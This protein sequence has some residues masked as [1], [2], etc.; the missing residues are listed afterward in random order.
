VQPAQ[1]FLTPM[2]ATEKIALAHLS[3]RGFQNV[4][5]EPD[6]NVPPDF[7]VD[8]RIAV[9][10]RRLNEHTKD[11]TDPRGLEE[12]AIPRNAQFRRLLASFGAPTD[13]ISWFVS[14][15]L[16]R[17]VRPW[18][19]LEPDLR[20]ALETFLRDH[21]ARRVEIVRDF[22]MRFN[23]ASQPHELVFVLGGWT[24]GG[25]GGFV[26]GELQRNIIIC[27]ADKNRK[28]AAVRTRYPEWWLALVDHIGYGVLDESDLEYVR[29]LIQIEHQWDKIVLINPS[30]PTKGFEL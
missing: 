21:D 17:P 19:E 29:P 16:R 9:E 6:G 3:A 4:I 13:G 12:V 15:S 2:D 10:V 20:V 26:V 8:D 23:R 1:R 11:D 14:Y 30:D 5:Y 28:I 22:R 24:D 7:L 27:I 18:K 25:S